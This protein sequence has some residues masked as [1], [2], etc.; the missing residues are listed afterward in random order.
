MY[1]IVKNTPVKTRSST[2]YIKKI[3]TNVKNV[4]YLVQNIKDKIKGQNVF[5]LSN[6]N[7]LT[8]K[9]IVFLHVKVYGFSQG[10]KS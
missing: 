4:Q 5:K 3:N 8:C 1:F 10:Q 2:K 7:I 6:I 9:N